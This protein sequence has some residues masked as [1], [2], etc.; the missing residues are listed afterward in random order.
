MGQFLNYTDC[1]CISKFHRQLYWIS[2]PPLPFPSSS[3]A[4]TT[5][6]ATQSP[7][8]LQQPNSLG[9]AAGFADHLRIDADDLAVVGVSPELLCVVPLS[10]DQEE[11]HQSSHNHEQDEA[12]GL[13]DVAG[14]RGDRVVADAPVQVGLTCG[15]VG[16]FRHF[17]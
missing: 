17:C 7:L 13:P 8:H 12:E 15:W 6:A 3:G 1:R 9:L 2:V 5:A 14:F 10:V 11:I 16:C 4:I